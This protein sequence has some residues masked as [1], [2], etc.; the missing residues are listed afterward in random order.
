MLCL[1]FY[2]GLLP[3]TKRQKHK[4]AGKEEKKEMSNKCKE[5]FT[6]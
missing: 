2:G 1:R 3:V 5:T 6:I 4:K